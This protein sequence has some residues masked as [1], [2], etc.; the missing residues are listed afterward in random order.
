VTNDIYDSAWLYFT[1][2]LEVFTIGEKEIGM[3]IK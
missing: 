2:Q 3:K 1:P